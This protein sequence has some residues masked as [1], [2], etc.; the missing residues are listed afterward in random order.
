MEPEWMLLSGLLFTLVYSQD[1]YYKANYIRKYM[2]CICLNGNRV[3][4]PAADELTYHEAETDARDD[5]E[6]AENLV[7]CINPFLHFFIFGQCAVCSIF[8]VFN[9]FL[10]FTIRAFFT[11]F[12]FGRA[13]FFINRWANIN[14][15]ILLILRF[16]FLRIW[17]FLEWCVFDNWRIAIYQISFRIKTISTCQLDFHEISL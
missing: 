12:L 4:D 2:C 13:I 8:I 16:W 10:R 3:G 1:I 17:V 15:M 14:F 11:I 7:W 6:A 9:F 5:V